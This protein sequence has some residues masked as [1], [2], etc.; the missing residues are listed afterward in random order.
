MA[1]QDAS[2]TGT[3]GDNIPTWATLLVQQTQETLSVM[4]NLAR[5]LSSTQ[6][7]PNLTTYDAV[8]TNDQT[9]APDQVIPPNAS[10]DPPPF[11]VP[12]T[13]SLPS[14][15]RPILD[16]PVRFNGNKK[17]FAA[18]AAAMD[19]KLKVDLKHLD[20]EASYKYIFS[21]LEGTA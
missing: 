7:T 6:S 11:N 17:N 19:G 18:W 13:T 8:S 21:R 14:S 3:N 1:E 16:H 12:N 10:S 4:N 9:N 20:D 2:M 15:K 5:I